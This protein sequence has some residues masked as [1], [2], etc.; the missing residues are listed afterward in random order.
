MILII[1]LLLISIALYY[2]LIYVLNKPQTPSYG[3]W[4]QSGG[5]G[6]I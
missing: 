2:Y 5:L 3:F 1:I 4:S 6:V